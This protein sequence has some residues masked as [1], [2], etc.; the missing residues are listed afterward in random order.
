M[1]GLD[2]RHVSDELA[3]NPWLSQAVFILADGIAYSLIG[4]LIG[5]ITWS[6]GSRR[7]KNESN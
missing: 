1:L 6:M 5:W 4:M 2:P 7:R 3:G